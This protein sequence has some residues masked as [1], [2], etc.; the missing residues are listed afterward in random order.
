[1]KL[2]E[3]GDMNMNFRRFFFFGHSLKSLALTGVLLISACDRQAPP[4]TTDSKPGEVKTFTGTWSATGDRQTMQLDSGHQAVIFKLTGSL[5]LSGPQRP[6]RG[7]RAEIIGFS[8]T[9]IGMQ[10]RSVWTDERGDKVFSTLRSDSTGSGK[11]INASFLG[12]TGRYAGVSGE[13]TF[14]WRHLINNENGVVSGRVVDLK[15]WARL[16]SPGNLPTTTG[17]KQ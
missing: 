13:Y 11:L 15:G 12:G 9:T 4:P 10:G 3:I 7:F 5:M 1:L 6:S 2:H 14:R 17:A 8:D 16:G